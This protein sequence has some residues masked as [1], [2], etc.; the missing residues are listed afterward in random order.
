MKLSISNIAWGSEDDTEMYGFISAHGYTG[1]EIAPTRLFPEKPYEH[2][3]EARDFAEKLQSK[4][5][6][7]ISSIQSI[8]YQRTENL[9]GTDTEKQAL[10]D[11]T[12]QAVLFA[13]AVGCKNLVFGCPRNRVIPGAEFL[14]IA[15]EFFHLIGDYA[16]SHGT[17]IAIEPNPPYYQ[18][19][20]INTTIEAFQ[21]CRQVDHVGIRVNVD[22]GTMI[23]YNE[24]LELITQNLELVNHIHISEPQ[25]AVIEKREVHSELLKIDFPNWRSIEMKNAGDLKMV[26]SVIR[27]IEE[28]SH[29]I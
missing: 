14:P 2:L 22:L 25:L 15:V 6:L 23:N 20:F 18:T 5:G 4:Y 10:V 11:Y 8:W 13:E 3:S 26:K 17:V 19:N 9:F 21:F 1:L 7:T 12:R 29:A 27:Y 28:C 16:A 24:S